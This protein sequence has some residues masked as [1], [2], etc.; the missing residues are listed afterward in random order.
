MI[1]NVRDELTVDEVQ[2][3]F[4][5]WMNCLAWATENGERIL[6]NKD[7]MV[8]FHVVNHKI[9]GGPGIFLHP[10]ICL[11]C[12]SGVVYRMAA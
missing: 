7:E 6:L 12:S 9:R 10:L 4:Y 11:V 3:V 8:F 5:N 2:S 1:P